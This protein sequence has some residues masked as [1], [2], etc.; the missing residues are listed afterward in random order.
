MNREKILETILANRGV[1]AD[2]REAFLNPDYDKHVHDPYLLN[3]M[4]KA[5]ERLVKA[6]EKRQKVTIYGDY[7]IDGLSAS[8][9][10][11]DAFSQFGIEVDAYIPDRF[12]EGYGLNFEA[13]KKIDEQDADVVVT[14]DCGS[15]SVDVIE[16][17]NKELN[18]D[19][20][21]TDHHTVGA[22]LPD[23]VAVINPKRKDSTYPFSDL[24][25]VGV[26]FKLVQAL[27]SEL[28]GLQRGQEKW[29]L[30]LVA[31]GTV[32]DVVD[33]RGE[34][35]AFVHFG[36]LVMSR[37]RRQGVKALLEI[38]GVKSADDI[39]TTTLG[40][41]VGPRLNASGRLTHAK[42]SLDILVATKADAAMNTAKEL[43]EMN[44]E[45]RAE[46]ARITEAARSLAAQDSSKVLVLAEENWS[47]GIVG[48]VAA[49]I[50]EE[51]QKPTFVMEI[52]P[53]KGVA[54]GSARSFG[55]YKAVDAVRAADYRISGGGHAAAAGVTIKIE[56]I[57]RFRT[58]VN[59]LYE[60]LGLSNQ[61]RHLA[62]KSDLTLDTFEHFS[63][64]LLKDFEL[65]KPFGR[66]N[67]TPI[68]LVQNV[69][70]G[71]QRQVGADKSH[72]QVVLQ[73]AHG[74]EIRG[75]SF[76]QEPISLDSIY[77]V[78]VELQLSTYRPGQ[79]ECIVREFLPQDLSS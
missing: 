22:T 61:Q 53:S 50:M 47:H 57:D 2:M 32:C 55:E 33:L 8:A 66:A 68:F 65:L 20:I 21:V 6:H 39:D 31:L 64:E 51:F 16:R 7:D 54:K 17:A 5:V 49:K 25:G 9:V 48:I 62:V 30:D 35:R 46:Q 73:D 67:P 44:L 71:Q 42:K 43:N 29:L 3:D 75:I 76:N 52:M 11:L 36:L 60:S 28:S 78:L 45:R 23:A 74:A 10:L 34:N 1:H 38:S 27:Q 40:F 59:S 72:L 70:L 24:A 77:S 18:L 15:V 13:L 63:V 56:D 4:K 12:T 26:A 41:R 14:V 69:R 37:T 19:I 79:V 58:T